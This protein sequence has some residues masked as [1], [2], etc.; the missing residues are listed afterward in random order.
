MLPIEFVRK[1]A[2]ER[3]AG[4]RQERITAEAVRSELEKACQKAGETGRKAAG[5]RGGLCGL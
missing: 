5:R 4:S 1:Y 2:V 3:I